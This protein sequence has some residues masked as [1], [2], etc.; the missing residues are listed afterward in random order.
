MYLL[1]NGGCV[2]FC[3]RAEDKIAS[4]PYK[5]AALVTN[6][7]PDR[8]LFS[9]RCYVVVARRLDPASEHLNASGGTVRI[10]VKSLLYFHQDGGGYCSSLSGWSEPA[11]VCNT[12]DVTLTFSTSCRNNHVMIQN[13]KPFFFM[14]NCGASQEITTET[15]LTL[16]LFFVEQGLRSLFN[17]LCC[18]PHFKPIFCSLVCFWNV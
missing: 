3:F 6:V 4:A 15:Y 13:V 14:A 1:H 12:C 2:V 10:C 8:A 18:I 11:S 5:E 17:W 9:W 7:S 16:W